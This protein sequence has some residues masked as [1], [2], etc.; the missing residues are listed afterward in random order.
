[1]QIL[2]VSATEL[3]IAPFLNAQTGTDHL[4]TGV[5]GQA[6]IYRLQKHL[7]N[8]SYDLIIQAGIAGCFSDD[9]ELGETVLVERDVFA[10]LGVFDQGDLT[11][12]FEMGLADKNEWPYQ[13]GWLVNEHPL[14]KNYHLKKSSAVSVNSLS[15]DNNIAAIYQKKYKAAIESMEGAAF[16]YT[17]LQE[18]IPFLQL[19]SISNKVGER[20][21]ENW[22]MKEAI[23]HLNDELQTLLTTTSTFV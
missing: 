23:Q 10:D 16:H 15:D 14:L 2:V 13:N 5:G 22:K 4:I 19:R 1:M 3:E 11:S 17:C 20:D 8:M 7:Q 6:C 21:K 9:L 12:V 18:K